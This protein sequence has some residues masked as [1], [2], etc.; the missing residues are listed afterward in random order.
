MRVTRG[1]FWERPIACVVLMFV[2]CSGCV[3]L[4]HT[5]MKGGI[6]SINIGDT[7][8]PKELYAGTGDEV[9]WLNNRDTP[10]RVG[11]LGNTEL[12]SISCEK[13]FRHFWI[14][15][16]IVIIQPHDYV[17]LCFS[18]PGKIR[19]NIW[20]DLEDPRRGISRTATIRIS[21]LQSREPTSARR[22]V[23]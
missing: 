5:T 7:I 15:Q 22:S 2:L 4:P 14:I 16:D 23:Y 17:S 20:W 13:G 18:R 8:V 11:F 1:L 10:V 3:D 21:L 6:Q 19:Y 9:R 12:G